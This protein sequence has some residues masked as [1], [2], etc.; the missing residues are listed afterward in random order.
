MFS[1]TNNV[2]VQ[3]S[4]DDVKNKQKDPVHRRLPGHEKSKLT[5]VRKLRGQV[6]KQTFT[7]IQP[8]RTIL[9][10]QFLP[11][12]VKVLHKCA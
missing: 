5:P 3:D 12:L 11:L 7:L 6:A 2:G 8:I 9:V 4:V 10:T 1:V